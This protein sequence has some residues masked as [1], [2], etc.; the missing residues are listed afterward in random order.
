[1]L[2]KLN[3]LQR[4]LLVLGSLLLL[5][6]ASLMAQVVD[7]LANGTSSASL[8]RYFSNYTELVFGASV[9][10]LSLLGKKF[11]DTIPVIGKITDGRLRFLVTCALV[12]VGFFLFNKGDFWTFVTT[13]GE[14]AI[15]TAGFY[16]F[17]FQGVQNWIAGKTKVVSAETE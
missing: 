12:G 5:A 13:K 14:T 4:K 7:T 10:V 11:G 16:A 8:F 9:F 15:F 17:I 2:N 6:T 1:M 3:I